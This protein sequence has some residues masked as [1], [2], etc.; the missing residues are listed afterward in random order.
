MS[1]AVK[2]PTLRFLTQRSQSEDRQGR[3]KYTSD[4]PLRPNFAPFALKSPILRFLT[5]RSQRQDRQGRKEHTPDPPS[6]PH[7]V[8][9]AVKSP[10][11][12]SF[13]T[14]AT[15]VFKQIRKRSN[16]KIRPQS[17][18]SSDLRHAITPSRPYSV[19]SSLSVSHPSAL[20]PFPTSGLRFPPSSLSS[21]PTP[22]LRHSH[23]PLLS[24]PLLLNCQQSMRNTR[25]VPCKHIQIIMKN[26]K[27]VE[28]SPHP[29]DAI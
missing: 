22:T 14:F 13:A 26:G 8:A 18:L 21:V 25:M 10:Y 1:F 15:F 19:T 20:S 5:Q 9:F 27:C 2:S 12:S 11:L 23:T 6:R 29:A 24:S 28:Q 17:F 16:A 4:P 3:K 7:F